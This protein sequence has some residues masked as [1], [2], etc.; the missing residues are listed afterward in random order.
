MGEEFRLIVEGRLTLEDLMDRG[1]KRVPTSEYKFFAIV[2]QIQKQTGGN[3]GDTLSNLSSV[4][5]ERKKM[6]AKV[7]SMSSEAKSSAAII[8]SLPFLVAGFLSVVN[9]EYLMLLFTDSMGHWMLGIGAFWL[10][11][12]IAV[13]HNMI[14]FKI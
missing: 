12:G 11:C 1:L 4:L 9:P 3:L 8:G 6:K 2:T 13:M 5:R 7:Q 14:N 10:A